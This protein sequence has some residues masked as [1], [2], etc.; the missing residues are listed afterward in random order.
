MCARGTGHCEVLR[1]DQTQ[2]QLRRPE[3]IRHSH[4]TVRA[5][6]RLL[7]RHIRCIPQYTLTRVNK[8]AQLE[9]LKKLHNGNSTKSNRMQF[10]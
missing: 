10:I 7:S 2:T 5:G 3:N 9:I 8:I 6:R 4:D 1:I